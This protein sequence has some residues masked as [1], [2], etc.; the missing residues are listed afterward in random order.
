MRSSG[1]WAQQ[2]VGRQVA[3]RPP[4]PQSRK[5]ALRYG[6][7]ATTGLRAQVN[8]VLWSNDMESL[9]ELDCTLHL[10]VAPGRTVPVH[11]RLSYCSHDPYAVHIAFHVYGPAPVR[12]AFGRDLLAEG[13]VRPSGDGDVRIWPGNAEQAGFLCLELSSSDGCALFTV[14]AAV[15]RP[16][17]MRTYHLVPA[18][19]EGASLDVDSELSRLLGEVA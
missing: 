13:T 4:H 1:L 10:V 11:T 19:L 7:S 6:T 2:A 5:R 12:W 9:T 15:V 3:T 8:S 16:W 18:G 14:P 17:L